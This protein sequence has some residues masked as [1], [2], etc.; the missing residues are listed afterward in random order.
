MLAQVAGDL[1]QTLT[2]YPAVHGPTRAYGERFQQTS[3]PGSG[4]RWPLALHL[5]LP[6]SCRDKGEAF[7][8]KFSH[9][10]KEAYD[11]NKRKS[12]IFAA[13]GAIGVDRILLIADGQLSRATRAAAQ[14]DA[15]IETV[16]LSSDDGMQ[17]LTET[18]TSLLEI[19]ELEPP[20]RRVASIQLACERDLLSSWTTVKT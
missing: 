20:P 15:L 13:M 3:S 10:D 19:R 14:K 17:L 16:D 12:E 8:N 4:V 18:I 1:P 9:A 11:L 7:R 5:Q 2:S 6:M